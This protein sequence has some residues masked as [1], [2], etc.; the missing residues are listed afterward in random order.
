MGMRLTLVVSLGFVLLLTL[1]LGSTTVAAQGNK[2]G[3]SEQAAKCKDGGYANW[4][5]K[6][7]NGFR[8]EGQCIRYLAQGNALAPAKTVTIEFLP[9]TGM[10]LDCGV[11]VHTTGIAPGTIGSLWTYL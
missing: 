7:G 2:G 11:A 6:N 5:D 1:T 8:N 10:A 9:V 4:V 3:N